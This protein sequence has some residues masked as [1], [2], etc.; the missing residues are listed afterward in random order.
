MRQ[1]HG[2][3]EIPYATS[4]SKSLK[5]LLLCWPGSATQGPGARSQE[6]TPPLPLEAGPLLLTL[7]DC[8]NTVPAGAGT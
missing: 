8:V 1:E 5:L 3:K 6:H 2:W 4:L 7:R